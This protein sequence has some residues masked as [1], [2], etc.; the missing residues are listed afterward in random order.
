[1]AVPTEVAEAP[2]TRADEP[3]GPARIALFAAVLSPMVLVLIGF[4]GSSFDSASR[5]LARLAALSLLLGLVS[6][7]R[8]WPVAITAVCL[9]V[10]VLAVLWVFALPDGRH[11]TLMAVALLSAA[12]VAI[13][14]FLDG[15]EARD[16]SVV[17]PV[18]VIA[19]VT[20]AAWLVSM[21]PI[22]LRLKVTAAESQM[23]ARAMADLERSTGRA[24]TGEPG[25]AP[26]PSFDCVGGQVPDLAIGPF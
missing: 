26:R 7:M 21:P 23:D 12:L 11:P 16:P 20:A 19:A 14:P 15:I 17:V 6:S 1:M 5:T 10:Y 3:A 18:V 2:A 24:P 4:V 25:Q 8:R 22:P 13:E 9:G